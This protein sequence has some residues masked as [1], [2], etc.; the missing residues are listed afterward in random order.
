[1]SARRVLL[2]APAR[3]CYPMLSPPC[4][5]AVVPA[6][7]GHPGP[8]AR[9][10]G[11]HQ[12]AAARRD[13]RLQPRHLQPGH[14]GGAGAGSRGA[15][16]GGEGESGD[17]CILPAQHLECTARGR[18]APHVFWRISE[19]GGEMA[20][21]AEDD[22]EARPLATE[23]SSG[24]Q[25][26]AARLFITGPGLAACVASNRRGDT[27]VTRQRGNITSSYILFAVSEDKI[28]GQLH[29]EHSY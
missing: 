25:T 12:V 5:G 7:P 15:G 26:A 10:G 17:S 28:G 18:P 9:A 19:D 3:P 1:M 16:A 6:D 24:L 4:R 29:L 21:A 23:P 20:E 22:V 2:L 11:G 27:Q 8:G 13:P 14:P